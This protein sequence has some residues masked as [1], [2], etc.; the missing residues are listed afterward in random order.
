MWTVSNNVFS[1][2]PIYYSYVT[3]S[4]LEFS[5]TFCKETYSFDLNTIPKVHRV[6]FNS[7]MLSAAAN[8]TELV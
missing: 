7:R 2:R 8:S 4:V 3:W 6:L 1:I 5:I